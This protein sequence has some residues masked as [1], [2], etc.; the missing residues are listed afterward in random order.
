MPF[1]KLVIEPRSKHENSLTLRAHK[2]N[3]AP[4]WNF[5]PKYMESRNDHKSESY[6]KICMH[7]TFINLTTLLISRNF[8]SVSK[9]QTLALSE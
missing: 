7:W 9:K 6:D 4:V 5:L 8:E 2:K 1:S 3:V